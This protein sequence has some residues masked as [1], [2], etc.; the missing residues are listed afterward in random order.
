[1]NWYHD[2]LIHPGQT[3][4]KESVLEYYVWPNATNEMY[5]FIDLCNGCQI[6]KSTNKGKQGKLPLKSPPVNDP[7]EII[8]VDLCGPWQIDAEVEKEVN[9]PKKRGK[10]KT[11]KVTETLEIWA[12]TIMDE[13][14][15][16]P[17][18]INIETKTSNNIALLVDSEWFCRYPRPL[19]CIY[20]NGKEFDSK[21]FCEMLDSYG[22]KKSPT[23]VKNPQG[24]SSH[25]RMHLVIAEMLRTQ[26]LVIPL[27]IKPSDEIRRI[28]QSVAF[29]IRATKSSVT[30]YSPGEMIYGRD[31]VTHHTAIA[32]W[33]LIRERKRIA[34][35]KN[36]EREN[37]SRSNHVWKVGQKCLVITRTDER[38]G[39]LRKYK[40]KGP[41]NILHVYDNGIVK[42][43]KKNFDEIMS[44][45]RLQLFKEIKS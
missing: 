9:D 43:E 33:D 38:G 8:S 10:M 17:E 14:S 36:N 6:D 40:H 31:M 28:L 1:M 27:K 24:N 37:K 42:I 12:L 30:K 44:T 32:N 2:A 21:E 26:E 45:R 13:V 18:I 11:I 39:K 19:K 34:Q 4:M 35:I 25:E 29:A 22:V 41:Y 20:D 7:W 23:T 3:R 16:W 5:E 15:G